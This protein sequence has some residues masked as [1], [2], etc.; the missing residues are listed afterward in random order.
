MNSKLKDINFTYLFILSTVSFLWFIFKEHTAYDWPAVDMMPFFERYYDKSF[1]INDFFT[2]ATSNEPNPRW[3]FGYLIIALAEL[4]K[5]NWYT[6]SYILKV[7]LVIF[8]PILYYVVLYLIVA[9][10]VN[11]RNLINIQIIL[12]FA[13]LIVIYPL[14][15]GIFSIAWWKPYFIQAAP[16]NISLFFGLSAILIKEINFHLRLNSYISIVLFAI[17]TLIH[18]AIGLFI[19]MFYILV[20][21]NIIKNNLKYFIFMIPFGFLLPAIFIKIFFSPNITLSTIDFINIYTIQNHSSHYHLA[22]FGT[23]TPVSW[24]YSFILMF[25]LL[26]IPIEAIILL[27]NISINIY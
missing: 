5:T 12:L 3:I 7:I 6:V 11:Q 22:N 25:I 13:I 1:L 23:H 14:F 18:P 8:M 15:S 20:S 24:I 10:F 4:F 26:I 17:A 19:I 16:Q 2:N 9:K 21:F 27:G